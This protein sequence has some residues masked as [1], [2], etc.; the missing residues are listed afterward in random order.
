[1]LFRDRT[2]I[3]VCMASPSLILFEY[4]VHTN[5]TQWG[6]ATRDV[7]Q[8]GFFVTEL[9]FPESSGGRSNLDDLLEVNEAFRY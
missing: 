2:P 5:Q 4:S 3:P 9:C 1:M 6:R 7:L 8:T